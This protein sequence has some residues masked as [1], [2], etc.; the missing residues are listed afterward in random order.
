VIRRILVALLI[1]MVAGA[2]R[3]AAAPPVRFRAP[4]RYASDAVQVVL[5]SDV[6]GDGHPD[7]IAS[8][9]QVEQL[10]AF[11]FLRNRGD[12]T[13]V[14][15]R[16]IATELG[17]TLQDVGD[18]NSDGVPDLIASHYFA[19]GVTISRGGG[20]LQFAAPE[21]YSTATHGGPT[22]IVDY[23]GDGIADLVSLSF[24]SGNPVRVH[25]FRGRADGTLS[26]NITTDAVFANAASPSMRQTD[27]AVEILAAEH[28]GHLVLIRVSAAGV[29]ARSIV[30]GPAMDLA[31]T[32]ADV[33][34]DGIADIV[35]TNDAESAAEQLFV[36]LANADGTFGERRAIDHPRHVNY[37]VVVRSADLDGDGRAD[38]IVSDFRA[39]ALYLFR[40][41]G[42][43]RFDEG[44]AIEAGGPVNTFAIGDV[45]G[46][47]R[48]DIVTANDDRTLSVII[49][50]GVP[51]RRRVTRSSSR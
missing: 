18:V 43:G 48:P 25:R 4:V 46:D 9:N 36:T 30:A 20:A 51:R 21:F 2:S 19:N 32:F 22:R 45:N 26:P 10:P 49:N 28:S 12:G 33:N 29:S 39:N 50:D 27:G 41:D 31:C 47:G 5:V 34:G 24:G 6:D 15:A 1:A 37:P 23:D 44:V 11:S 35:D 38:L 42:T 17:Q 40:G 8:G 3:A 7:I 14:D 16:A 13:F